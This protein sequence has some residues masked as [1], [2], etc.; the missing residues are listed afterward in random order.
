MYKWQR[1]TDKQPQYS[2]VAV[3]A[4]LLEVEMIKYNRYTGYIFPINLTTSSYRLENIVFSNNKY[5]KV[6]SK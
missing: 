4:I 5:L 6:Q 3:Q 2:T 1:M